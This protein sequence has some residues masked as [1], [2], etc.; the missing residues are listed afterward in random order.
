M[1]Q[2]SLKDFYM[3]LLKIFWKP[4]GHHPVHCP[5][6]VK[7][8]LVF[9]G[10]LISIFV[11]GLISC[12]GQP[13]K[14]SS[15]SEN[16][17]D[18]SVANSLNGKWVSASNYPDGCSGNNEVGL[19]VITVMGDS[20]VTRQRFRFKNS[21]MQRELRYHIVS[22]ENGLVAVQNKWGMSMR[23]R[24]NNHDSM[25]MIDKDSNE[26]ELRRCE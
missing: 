19:R 14:T 13:Q 3:H 9:S 25:T 12:V 16:M 24:I 4:D 26:L 11:L 7:A 18:L 10:T 23:Y 2:V 1:L 5:V 15:P 22:V 21:I 20:V 17:I 8:P 6:R